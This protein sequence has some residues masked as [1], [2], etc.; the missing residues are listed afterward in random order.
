LRKYLI[1]ALAACVAVGVVA[2]SAPAQDPSGIELK[3]NLVPPKSGTK[4]KPKSTK[5]HFVTTNKDVSQTA[6]RIKIWIPKTLKVSNKGFPKCTQAVLGDPNRGPDACPK[7]SEVGGGTATARAG[8]NVN[9]TNPPQ[10]PFD[11]R[12][13]VTGKTSLVFHIR[14]TQPGIEIVALTPAKLKK[15]S[16]KYGQLL[17]VTIPREPAQFYLG[18]YNGLEELNVTLGAKRGKNMLI[19]SVGCKKGKAPFKTEIGFAPNPGPPKA[20]KLSDTANAKCRK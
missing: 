13:F 17:D 11:V 3:V 16:G 7:G 14:S 15:A 12:A 10:L 19:S 8:V 18:Q 4:K 5:I 9:P 1:A 20:E 6:D 2:V